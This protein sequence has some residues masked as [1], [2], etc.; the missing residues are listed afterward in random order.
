MNKYG[1]YGKLKAKQGHGKALASILL[2]AAEHVSVLDT[3]HLYL[4]SQDSTDTDT[5]WVTEVWDTKAAHDES[6]KL[7]SVRALIGQA[8]PILDGLPSG[9]TALNILGG[10]GL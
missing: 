5:I 4:V 3:C 7:E 6:L 10:Y 1:L 2:K 8:M 9:G